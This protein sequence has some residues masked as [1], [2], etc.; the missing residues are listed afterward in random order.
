MKTLGKM[1]GIQERQT[2]HEGTG[3]YA[4]NQYYRSKR[5]VVPVSLDSADIVDRRACAKGCPPS[6]EECKLVLK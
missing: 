3:K 4:V 2:P 6:H 5:S 1:E